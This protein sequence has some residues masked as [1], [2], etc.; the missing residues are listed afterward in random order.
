MKIPF[1]LFLR[2]YQAI[3][4]V[5]TNSLDGT[6]TAFVSRIVTGVFTFD[7]VMGKTLKGKRKKGQKRIRVKFEDSDEI[8]EEEATSL[9]SKKAE[10]IIGN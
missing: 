9:N 7:E 4:S 1:F 2:C 3:K 8:D 5:Y 10:A 6:A